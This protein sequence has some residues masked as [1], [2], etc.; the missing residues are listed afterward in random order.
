MEL[1]D[2]VQVISKHRWLVIAIVGAAL[3]SSVYFAMTRE[4]R[5]ESTATVAVTPNLEEIGGFFSADALNSLLGTYAQTAESSSTLDR[6]RP[7]NG[8][9]L[10][11]DVSTSVEDNT[12]ILRIHARATDPF[13]AQRTATAVA[14]GFRASIADTS[15]VLS[16]EIVGPAVVPDTPVQP[17]PPLIIAVGLVLGIG[18]AL[19][20]A[21]GR[22]HFRQRVETAEDLVGI[23]DLPVIGRLPTSRRLQREQAHVIWG[24]PH[25]IGLQE[26]LRALR[27]NIEF[28]GSGEPS[29][30]QI[31]S[32][33][34]GE[35]KSTTVANLGIA[36]AQIGIETIIVDCDLRRPSQHLIL[37]VENH[38]GVSNMLAVRD[39]A[40][41]PQPTRFPLLW[42]VPSGPPP[43]NSTEMLHICSAWAMAQ[44]RRHGRLLLIDSPPILPVSDPRLIA[45]HVDAVIMVIAADGSRRVSEVRSAL[46]K[47]AFTSA[48]T[49]G[50]VLNRS[51][52]SSEGSGGYGYGYDYS[53]SSGKDDPAPEPQREP[54]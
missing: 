40:I 27:T 34:P 49:I 8:G 52:E 25:T 2:L 47:L 16:T 33:M 30:I 15:K 17:R 23:T 5:Y 14:R 48:N 13:E 7:F 4:A 46:E 3:A 38:R 12:G 36:F 31:T 26:S 1:R 54:A 6:A 45:P 10:V 11:G 32:A 9:R 37:G 18:L 39:E 50:F 19:L 28:Q 22:E 21:F 51:S 42:V 44:L 43:P 20:M 29:A 35:G 24:E 41:E 53:Y